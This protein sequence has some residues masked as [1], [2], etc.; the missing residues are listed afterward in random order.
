MPKIKISD[1]TKGF[2]A[3]NAFALIL[4]S[5]TA[6][7]FKKIN[8][9]P[10]VLIFSEFVI[11]PLLMGIISA[12]YWRN[13]DLSG[14]QLAGNALRNTFLGCVVSSVFMQEG[15]IC[16]IIVSPLLF[17]FI[18]IGE[19]I[20]RAMFKRNDQKLN[21]SIIVLLLGI[22]VF[23]SLSKHHYENMVADTMVIKAPPAKVWQ[24]VVAYKRIEAKPNY[25]LFRIGMPS[26]V[27]ST[28][29]G[30]HLGAN[31]K[32]IFSNGYVFD[33]KISTYDENRN[34]TF[35][36]THQPRDPEIM[37][38]IDILRGQFLLK[39]NGDGTTTLTGNSWYRLYVFPTWYYDLW[40]SSITRNVHL[41][42]M[43]HIKQLS[44]IE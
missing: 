17:T 11:I 7:V 37:G 5:L 35:D 43:D 15:V 27:Q 34:L 44:E 1:Y 40:A 13:M 25:W 26:P 3:S 32:C 18:W 23:D 21:T 39:D 14:Y 22:F 9:T 28:A 16:L 30:Y 4:L 8:D 19:G 29:S 20:G 6:L 2:I 10:G 24:Y 33:E 36:I 31:R 42:V 41:R 38:H 12:W